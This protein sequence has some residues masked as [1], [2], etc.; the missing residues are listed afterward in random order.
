M[1]L[2]R[3]RLSSNPPCLPAGR[4][5]SFA[6]GGGRGELA[7]FPANGRFEGEVAVTKDCQ[8]MIEND[9][10]VRVVL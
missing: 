1:A 4:Q 10:F 6:K 5:P 9:F 7:T 8:K 2:C 3:K